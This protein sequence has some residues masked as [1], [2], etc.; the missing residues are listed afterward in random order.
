MSRIESLNT[1]IVD[2][3]LTI[4]LQRAKTSDPLI[5]QSMV[6]VSSL[7]SGLFEPLVSETASV[8]SVRVGDE[9]P[10]CPWNSPGC[11]WI[12]HQGGV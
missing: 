10:G 11:G 12:D 9:N 5:V 8:I 2:H 4:N 3:E 6:N 1:D 7:R